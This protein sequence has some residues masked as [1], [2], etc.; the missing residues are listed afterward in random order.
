MRPPQTKHR[1]LMKQP[2]PQSIHLKDYRPP[3]YLVPRVELDF[4][5]H[6]DVTRVRSVLA[7]TANYPESEPARP[8]ELDGENLHL[9]SLYLDGVALVAGDYMLSQD[10][11]VVSNVPRQFSLEI[12]TEIKPYENT[13][14]EG[15]YQSGD[16][17]CTQNEP[18]GFRHITYFP[19]RSDVMSVYTTSI[20]AARERYPVL[21]ANGNEV[22][23]RTLDNG[24]H[25]VKWHDPFAKPCYLFAMVAGDLGVVEDSFTTQSGREIAIR[26]FV[27]KGNEPRCGH[28]IE[29]LKGAMAWDEQRFGLEYDLDIYMVV[30]VD[31]FNA[32]AME[33]KGLNI[34]NSQYV[35]ADPKTATDADYQGIERVIAHEYFHN[36]TGNRVTCRDWFQLTL[37]EGLTVFRDQEFSSDM[38]SRAVKRIGDVRILRE[39]QFAEDSGPTSHPI[40]PASY[41]EINNFYT[42]TVYNKGAEVIRMIHTLIGED[43]F[44]RGMDLYFERHDGQAVTTEDFVAA[45]ADASDVDLSLFQRWYHQSGTPTCEITMD[46]NAESQSCCLTVRQHCPQTDNQ[47]AAP[48]HM[49]M[50]FGLLG[51]DGSDL[52]ATLDGGTTASD[53]VEITGTEQSFTFDN[54]PE[55]PV[56]SFFREF[57]APV[58]VNFDYSRDDLAFLLAHDNDPFNRYE[59]GQRLA[60]VE[61]ERLIANGAPHATAVAEDITDA[62]G[63][64]LDYGK[65]DPAFVAEALVL[66]SVTTLVERMAVCDFDGAHAARQALS[67]AIA[68]RHES[69]MTAF[70]R[71]LHGDEGPY[72]LDPE[73]M[74][75]RALKNTLL[76]YL[77]RVESS[78]HLET[79][80]SQFEHADNMTDELGALRALSQ[81]ACAERSMV[82]KEFRA[83]WH[84]EGLVMNKWLATQAAAPLP[85]TLTV[86]QA[87]END[88]VFDPINPNKIRALFGA[89]GRNLTQ[90]HHVTGEGYRFLAGKIIDIDSFNPSMAASLAECYR[91]YARL[92]PGRK[93]LMRPELERIL[94]HPGLSKDVFEIVTKTLQDGA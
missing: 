86:V 45:M 1:E 54:V 79:A 37:K 50:A 65:Q 82:F 92:D 6:P 66:P 34:F 10:R 68:E 36:W 60:V 88:N 85:D 63:R 61:L 87:L 25:M 78:T 41:I 46:W 76:A 3:D 4:A 2:P 55:C 20:E 15:L 72:T 75:R 24:R 81:V 89:F 17:L 16:I 40:K 42:A 8:L 70:Y 13:A 67:M 69:K 62:F 73:A 52:K 39:A 32:G 22:E 48:F 26:F 58:H 43:A 28:A 44:R 5:I 57:S 35:L 23:T 29:S 19:D 64:L 21:L 9:V 30:A 71:S 38:S 84:T 90:F 77:T 93:D 83:R 80:T 59:A 56:P 53:M 51:A 74:G 7:V 33:N 18:E 27:D 91:K 47:P 31:T 11:L 12:E 49:P 14:L 94:A